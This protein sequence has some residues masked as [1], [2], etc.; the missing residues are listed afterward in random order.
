MNVVQFDKSGFAVANDRRAARALEEERA[1][2]AHRIDVVTRYVERCEARLAQSSRTSQRVLRTRRADALARLDTLDS[3]LKNVCKQLH[4]APNVSADN[5]GRCLQIRLACF[6]FS[7]NMRCDTANLVRCVR[8]WSCHQPLPNRRP[9]DQYMFTACVFA[10]CPLR[11]NVSTRRGVTLFEECAAVADRIFGNVVVDSDRRRYD[12]VA[13]TMHSFG[14]PFD[15]MSH[16]TLAALARMM[17][18]TYRKHDGSTH[19]SPFGRRAIDEGSGDVLLREFRFDDALD[20]SAHALRARLINMYAAYMIVSAGLNAPLDTLVAC[21]AEVLAGICQ[22]HSC[23]HILYAE[24]G[25]QMPRDIDVAFRQVRRIAESAH[26]KSVLVR[27]VRQRV[28]RMELERRAERY[29]NEGL[30]RVL[31]IFWTVRE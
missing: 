7:E 14:V 2:I 6:H 10:A 1:R 31:G 17:C 11:L 25:A 15:Y 26:L 22:A 5:S 19:A 24:R 13:P 3:A 23:A 18:A 28:C 21:V 20:E 27:T 12:G 16:G 30:E 9:V 4:A 8:S 29:F